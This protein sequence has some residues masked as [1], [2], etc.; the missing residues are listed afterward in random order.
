MSNVVDLTSRLR[1]GTDKATEGKGTNPPKPP[2]VDKDT[3]ALWMFSQDVD[4]LVRHAVAATGLPV[5]EVAAI[6][7]HRLGTLAAASERPEALAAFCKTLLDRLVSGSDAASAG[8]GTP[9]GTAA[10]G[11][12]RKLLPNGGSH[13]PRGAP[14]RAEAESDAGATEGERAGHGSTGSGE[15]DEGPGRAG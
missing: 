4:T 8:Q 13:A 1:K 11:S 3:Y 6:L 5:E 2:R 7:A 14:A 10:P 9:T 12:Q 15:A